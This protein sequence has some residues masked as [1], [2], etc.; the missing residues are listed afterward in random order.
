MRPN[1]ERILDEKSN[2][3]EEKK[4]LRES[5]DIDSDF[6]RRF[7]MSSRLSDYPEFGNLYKAVRKNFELLK[8]VDQEQAL[9]LNDEFDRLI[10]NIEGKKRGRIEKS[11]G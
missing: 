10:K 2:L 7:G 9:A 11:Q 5:V 8:A 3:K 4:I 1:L 6:R